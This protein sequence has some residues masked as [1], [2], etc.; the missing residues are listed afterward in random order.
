MPE[1]KQAYRD[2]AH[3][4]HPD[5]HTQNERLQRKAL[6][7]T[8]ESNAAYDCICLHLDAGRA[9]GPRDNASKR[10]GSTETII[11]CPECGTKN[12]SHSP[13]N[14]TGARCGRCGN[15]LFRGKQEQQSEAEWAHRT[16]CHDGACTGSIDSTGRRT[17]CGRTYEEGT[18]AE[19]Q[20]R[21]KLRLRRKK[22]IIYGSVG[23]GILLLFLFV[24][25][26][27]RSPSGDRIGLQ[28]S[29]GSASSERERSVIEE[30]DRGSSAPVPRP[31][32]MAPS[33]KLDVPIQRE[34]V[35]PNRLRTGSAPY[36][37]GDPVRAFG[38]NRGQCHQ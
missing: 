28:N 23:I 4:W 20:K 26:S 34:P 25:H 8:K 37:G 16:L 31:L 12:R 1:V 9:T 21:R 18:S 15:Y 24:L 29:P 5:R 36:T 17:T 14:R 35:D 2:L 32:S 7:K 6:E 3:V 19:Q 33:E 27:L 30:P 13:H 38:N 10:D 11:V 22:A